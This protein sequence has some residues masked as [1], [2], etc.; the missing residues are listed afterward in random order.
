M[1]KFAIIVSL[2]LFFLLTSTYC[3]SAQC[4]VFFVVVVVFNIRSFSYYGPV[5]CLLVGWMVFGIEFSKLEGAISE[6][7]I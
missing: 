7:F 1:L 4:Y 6:K 5:G 2:P 3:S